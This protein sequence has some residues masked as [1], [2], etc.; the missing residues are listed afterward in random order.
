MLSEQFNDNYFDNFIVKRY[1]LNSVLH[2]FFNRLIGIDRDTEN[3]LMGFLEK[4]VYGKIQ[5]GKLHGK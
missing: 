1:C 4:L 2:M 3:V 5:R